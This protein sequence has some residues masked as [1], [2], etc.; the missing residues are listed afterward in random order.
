[1]IRTRVG[2]AGGKKKAP[3]YRSIGDHTE[4]VQVDYDPSIISYA[5]LL[6]IIWESHRPTDRNSSGQYMNVI[7]YHNNNQHDLALAS[8]MAWQKKIGRPVTTEVLP[9]R[10]FTMAEDYHQKYIL[11]QHSGILNEISRIYPRHGDLVA[12]TAAARLNGYAGGNGKRDQ[13]VRELES[14]G[15]SDNGKRRLEQLVRK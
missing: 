14:L 3:T 2:Y 6:D 5:K 12:S 9:L 13:L 7:F 1:V 11:K 15:L 10:S 4:T 8:R